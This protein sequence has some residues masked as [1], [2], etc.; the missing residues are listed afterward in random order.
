MLL[1]QG[2]QTTVASTRPLKNAAAASPADRLTILTSSKLKPFFASAV[3]STKWE[4]EYC[5]SAMVLPFNSAKLLM[6]GLTINASLPSELSLTR[7]A[8]TG[9]PLL[10]G[11]MVSDQVWQLASNCPADKAEMESV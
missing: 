4:M 5:S 3:A 7:I 10:S 2:F 9:T 6:V 8:L 1:T 11:A